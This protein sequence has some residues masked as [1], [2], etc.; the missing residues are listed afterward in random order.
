MLKLAH[1]FL[2]TPPFTTRKKKKR[3]G[4][5]NQP[6]FTA[7]WKHVV[8]II[9]FQTSRAFDIIAETLPIS[10][11][12]L[13]IIRR[14][15]DQH[16]AVPLGGR[17]LRCLRMGD[18]LE[19]AVGW[20]TIVQFKHRWVWSSE[21]VSTTW[22]CF[23]PN[24]RVPKMRWPCL[25]STQNWLPRDESGVCS[26]RTVVLEEDPWLTAYFTSGGRKCQIILQIT[27]WTYH[28]VLPKC[29]KMQ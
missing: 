15:E 1:Q 20:G 18:F 12:F 29:S 2:T 5:T 28:L 19:V 17:R 8:S 26:P 24:F 14:E 11:A 13:A 3:S 25:A 16:I 27:D 9:C 4:R 6:T 21:D 7:G 22:V 10:K 23:C